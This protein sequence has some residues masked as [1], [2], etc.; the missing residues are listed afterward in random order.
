MARQG[1]DGE[2]RTR[3]QAVIKAAGGAGR[4]QEVTRVVQLLEREMGP[5][6]EKKRRGGR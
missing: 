5:W 4:Q 1:R 3:A 2:G 6:L